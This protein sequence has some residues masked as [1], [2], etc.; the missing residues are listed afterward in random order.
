MGQVRVDAAIAAPADEVFERIADFTSWHLWIPRIVS[1][2]M[3]P[4]D[5]EGAVGAV[6]TLMLSDANTV[7][8]RLT[9]KDER[10][11][12]I[13]YDFPDG[14]PFPVTGY[15]ARVEVEA[16]GNAS[17]VHWSSSFNAGD[18]VSERVGATFSG[19]YTTFL[20]NLADSFAS[21]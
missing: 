2:T 1:T 21:V 19:I 13:G 20:A 17:I 10:K 12:V 14:S 9:Q 7:R 18:Q 4:G 3:D 6:R 8:E 5:E 15:L 16:T 11:R